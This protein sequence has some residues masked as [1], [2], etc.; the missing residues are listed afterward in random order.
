MNPC[1]AFSLHGCGICSPL[2]RGPGGF[3][4]TR[5][6]PAMLAFLLVFWCAVV[7]AGMAEDNPAPPS[8]RRSPPPGELQPEWG[9][10]PVP[11][12]RGSG[13]LYNRSYVVTNYHVVEKAPIIHVRFQSGEVISAK[14]VSKDP[15]NDI[16]L[17]RLEKT[18]A[19]GDVPLPIADSVGVRTG[20]KVFTIGFP[21]TDILG[22]RAKYSEGTIGSVTGYGDDPPG[23]FRSASRSTRGTAAGRCST[24]AAR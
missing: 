2:Q 6:L 21:M 7:P 5:L 22:K 17:L 23:F 1:A 20:D 12:A 3:V 11:A 8:S 16:A 24:S 14:I 19:V 9:E 15:V 4:P 18:P 13:F 10:M